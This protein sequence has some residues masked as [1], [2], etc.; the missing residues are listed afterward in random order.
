MHRPFKTAIK[1]AFTDGVK[2][3]MTSVKWFVSVTQRTTIH[4]NLTSSNM[5]QDISQFIL[6]IFFT[7]SR[8]VVHEV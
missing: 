6:L 4:Y 7:E 2:I 1:A 5:Q 8:N 3:A